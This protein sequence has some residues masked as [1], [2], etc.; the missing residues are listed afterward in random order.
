VERALT[1]C[2]AEDHA[3]VVLHDI[4]TGA[5]AHLDRFLE[6]ARAC[7]HTFQQ[8]FPAS[9]MPIVRGRIVGPIDAYLTEA[10]VPA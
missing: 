5:M 6:T 7:G 10:P 9:C 4:P 3:L 8:P 2:A 1:L